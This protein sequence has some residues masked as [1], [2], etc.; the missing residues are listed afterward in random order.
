MQKY[1]PCPKLNKKGTF[2]KGLLSPQDHK[3]PM[4][5]YKLLLQKD[6]WE[7]LIK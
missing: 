7:G 4:L 6:P 5:H 3:M 1:N 2:L